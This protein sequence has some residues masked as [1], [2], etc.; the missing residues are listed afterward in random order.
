MATPVLGSASK[1]TSGLARFPPALT[2]L[3]PLWIT[4][5]LLIAGLRLAAADSAA[6]AAPARFAAI[7][8][9]AERERSAAHS[10]DIR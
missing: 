7:A 1:A 6:A 2:V 4:K 9:A 3:P 10:H 8:A 5:P